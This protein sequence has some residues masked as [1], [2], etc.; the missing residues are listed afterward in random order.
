MIITVALAALI[1][2]S[3]R[4][5][6]SDEICARLRPFETARLLGPG[7]RWVEFHWSFDKESIWSWGCLHSNDALAKATC[8]WLLG[9]TNQEF[10]MELPLRIMTCH[11]YR[12]PRFASNDW[13]K[14]TGTIELQGA[15][16]RRVLLDF[17]YG[18]LPA[19]EQATRLSVSNEDASADPDARPAIRSLNATIPNKE[20]TNPPRRSGGGGPR[21]GGGGK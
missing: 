20:P 9:H 15:R 10:S 3:A 21:S 2:S 13:R 16:G 17:A 19:G 18:I 11:G 12:F 1:F 6:R 14:I 5:A 4:A 8:A 7:V